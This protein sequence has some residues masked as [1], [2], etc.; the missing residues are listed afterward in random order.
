MDVDLIQSTNAPRV[1]ADQ[2]YAELVGELAGTRGAAEQEAY[3]GAL[4]AAMDPYSWE[5]EGQAPAT[6]AR[7]APTTGSPTPARTPS[8]AR[9]RAAGARASDRKEPSNEPQHRPGDHVGE[10]LPIG[11]PVAVLRTTWPHYACNEMAG[12]AWHATVVARAAGTATVHFTNA[13]SRDGRR[14]KDVRL[15]LQALRLVD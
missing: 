4:K 12:E 7:A 14:Y 2:G 13:R 11:A 9:R 5:A 15:S 6:P 8:K 3:E 10:D 1:F